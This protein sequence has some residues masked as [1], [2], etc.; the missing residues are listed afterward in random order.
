MHTY[1]QMNISEM[2]KYPSVATNIKTI[3]NHNIN[4]EKRIDIAANIFESLF[5]PLRL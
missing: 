4:G 3:I 1:G 5:G 2:P